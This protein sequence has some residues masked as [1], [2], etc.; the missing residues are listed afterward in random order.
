MNLNPMTLP[1]LSLHSKYTDKV[2][3]DRI[4]VTFD[5]PE[6][7]ELLWELASKTP[8]WQFKVIRGGCY[9][10]DQPEDGKT[11]TL[12]ATQIAI[13]QDGEA[14][15]SIASGYHGRNKKIF[16]DNERIKKQRTSGRNEGK[17]VTADPKRAYREVVKNFHRRNPREV[18]EHAIVE[19][20]D[21][22]NK[23]SNKYHSQVYEASNH[24]REAAWTVAMANMDLLQQLPIDT[25]LKDELKTHYDTIIE[26]TEHQQKAVRMAQSLKTADGKSAV[27]VSFGA[28]YVLAYKGP[29]T[30]IASDELP[31]ELRA[32]LGMLKLS[33][34]N[35]LVDGIGVRVND[36]VFMVIPTSTEGA[37]DE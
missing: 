32:P 28:T 25:K 4:E 24:L 12:I 23:I 17:M 33:E 2:P 35:V 11:H 9:M 34:E 27:V 6:L 36:K 14:L 10:K 8:L 29:A 22:L 15:G 37:K 19:L 26:N 31:E 5:L 16:I 21:R 18:T 20:G 3:A 7:K 30:V 1:N 13:T